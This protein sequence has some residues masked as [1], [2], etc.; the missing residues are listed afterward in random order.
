MVEI[1]EESSRIRLISSTQSNADHYQ[2]LSATANEAL[3]H[4]TSRVNRTDARQ[5]QGTQG[6]PALWKQS[7][8]PLI[9][10]LMHLTG[11]TVLAAK[12]VDKVSWNVS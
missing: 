9:R 11:Q 6:T 8:G 1:L 3:H 2:R 4:L 5:A 12:W 7:R 10:Y